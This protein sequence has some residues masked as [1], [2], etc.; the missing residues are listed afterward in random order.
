[1]VQ[2]STSREE[3]KFWHNFALL[4]FSNKCIENWKANQGLIKHCIEMILSSQF[5][6][7]NDVN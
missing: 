6:V 7:K 3:A 5:V 4:L 2:V 1:M